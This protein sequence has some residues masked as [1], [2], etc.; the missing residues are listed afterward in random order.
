MAT[1][2]SWI[3]PI[4][5]DYSAAQQEAAIL[6]ALR[7]QLRDAIL[8]QRT[9]SNRDMD[10]CVYVVR[11]TGSVVI[12]YPWG[13]SPVLYVGR[14]QA[15]KRLAMH[16]KNWLHDAHRFGSKV[17][18]ELRICV[19]RRTNRADFFKNVEADL[20]DWFEQKYGAIPFFNSRRE[21]SY[22][23]QVKNYLPTQKTA[24]NRA[25]GVGSGNRPEWAVRPLRSNTNV[26]VYHKGHHPDTERD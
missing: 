8:S 9:F 3:E 2:I 5:L 24:L 7:K 20:I 23:G 6:K 16:L 18:V 21:T 12:A 15:P 22:A 4:Q 13:D 10:R 14:G 1:T 25:L 19:P 26:H 17:G 11:M